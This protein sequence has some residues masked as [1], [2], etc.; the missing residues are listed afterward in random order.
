[1]KRFIFL[2]LFLLF[3]ALGCK[4]VEQIGSA[5]PTSTPIPPI[6]T[7]SATASPTV[8][9]EPTPLPTSTRVAP[10]PVTCSDDSCLEAC[11][12]RIN[13]ELE[14]K[15][16]GEI[17][18]N[19]AGADANFNLVSYIVEGDLILEPDILWVPSEYKTYQ[20]DRAAHERV[21]NYFISLI[22]ADQRKWIT[23]YTVFT[24]G[25][26]NTLAWVGKMDYNDN[27]RWE[28]GVDILDSGEPINLTETITHEVAHLIT[29]NSDQI[30]QSEDFIYSPIQNPAVCKQFMTTEGCSTPESYINKFHQT[31][32]TGIYE[33]WMEIV[34]NVDASDEEAFYEAVGEFYSKYWDHFAEPYAATNIKEDMAVSFETFILR[35]MATGNGISAKKMRFFYNYPELVALR[36]QMIQSMCSYAQ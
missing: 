26:S 12:E 4:V 24:D 17:G 15:P 11:L 18:G 1:M 19:Y 16:Q 32:W 34:Y 31:F 27:S 21:W 14:T 9:A 22:P 29:L 23:K 33:D 6:A 25:N 10:T 7:S 30:I 3:V 5:P 13:Q 2:S 20:E 35:P 28:L 36:K 8:E